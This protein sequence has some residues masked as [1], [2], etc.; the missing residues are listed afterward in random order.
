MRFNTLRS[1]AHNIADSLACG[2]GFMI[3]VYE[4]SVFEEASETSTG[5]LEVNF[6]TGTTSSTTSAPLKRAIELYAEALGPLCERHGVP[7]SSFSQLTARYIPDSTGF[8]R[9]DV[10]ISDREGRSVEDHYVGQPGRRPRVV[11]KLGRVRADRPS[12]EK[13]GQGPKLPDRT[14]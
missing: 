13:T 2:M 4:T 7:L 9:F 10:F 14:F 5:F 6:L 8:G 12:I 11:D 3:D 1:V